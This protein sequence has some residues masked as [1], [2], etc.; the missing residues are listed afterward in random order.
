MR[1]KWL[2]SFFLSA[3]LASGC[4]RLPDH[5]DRT[6]ERDLLA[7]TTVWVESYGMTSEL[8]KV[9]YIE[10]ATCSSDGPSCE[11]DMLLSDA[12]VE[13]AGVEAPGLGCR[14]GFTFL[15]GE[16]HANVV[17]LKNYSWSVLA[18]E[19]MHVKVAQTVRADGDP[20]HRLPVWQSGEG[21]AQPCDGRD[22]SIQ[23]ASDAL[24]RKG[25]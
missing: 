7:L 15:V 2:M 22:T 4:S 25:L 12:C 16:G 19:L 23:D 11:G 24:A 18:H 6:P 20:D 9:N 3:G 13:S 21:C 17:Y 1:N 8:P 10:T 5:L 14:R